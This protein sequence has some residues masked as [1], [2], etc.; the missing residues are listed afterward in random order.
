MERYEVISSVGEGAYGVVLKCRDRD[1]GKFNVID[2]YFR[3]IC[4]D[5]KIQRE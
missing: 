5:Q 3:W 1:T 4:C 2:Q